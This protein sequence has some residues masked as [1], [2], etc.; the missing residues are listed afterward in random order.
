MGADEAREADVSGRSFVQR[1]GKEIDDQWYNSSDGF[2]VLSSSPVRSS[3]SPMEQGGPVLSQSRWVRYLE[4]KGDPGVEGEEKEAPVSCL[5][6]S[7]SPCQQNAE[8]RIGK[9][10]Q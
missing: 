8:L 10:G 7:Q 4:T 2:R 9:L 5:A 3:P 6:G 1:A